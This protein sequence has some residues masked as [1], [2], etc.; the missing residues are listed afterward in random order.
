MPTP[1]N[2]E[3]TA[4]RQAGPPLRY[5]NTLRMMFHQCQRKFYWWKIRQ[6]DQTLRPGYFSFGSAWHEIKGSWYT[7][8][9]ANPT[10][11]PGSDE[12]RFGALSALQHGLDFWDNSGAID[13][14]LDSRTNLTRMWQ[15]YVKDQPTEPF[16]LV[17]GGAE[18]GWLWP[19]PN[20]GGSASRYY[21]GGSMDGY[22]E[23]PG[24]GLMPNEEKTTSIWLSDFYIMQW[25]FSSQ[26]TG[27]IWYLSNLLGTERVHGAVI[28]MATKQTAKAATPQF[29]RTIE[30]RTEADFLEFERDWRRDIES[31]ERSYDR[32]HFPKTTDTINC[33]GGIGKSS[34]PY[35]GMCLSGMPPS[36]LSPQSFPN[37]CLRT[38]E[39]QPWLRQN[40]PTG[41]PVASYAQVAQITKQPIRPLIFN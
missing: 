1:P 23:W 16:R 25:R 13:N 12:W 32:W 35:R 17:K 27:Y 22:V 2:I 21:L 10:V 40:L 14:K 24:Y 5:D 39:W 19:L 37:L 34:C 31:I 9:S 4:L 36:L 7:F 33:T 29:A 38:E 11:V 8:L 20:A 26:I 30:T 41:K 3:E 6:V 28:S 15:A 18:L